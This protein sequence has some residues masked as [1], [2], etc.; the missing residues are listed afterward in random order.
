MAST[1][2]HLRQWAP[3]LDAFWY[4]ASLPLAIG[5][6]ALAARW[7]LEVPNVPGVLLLPLAYTAYRGGLAIGLA[8]ALLHMAHSAMFF[9][10]PGTLF[11]YGGGNLVRLMVIVTVAPAMA[12][13]IGM[14]RRKSDLAL[15]EL[16]AARKT[17]SGLPPSSKS[18]SRNG[19]PNS[20]GWPVTIR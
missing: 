7:G 6:V 19:L 3:R 4:L 20:P 9:S 16:E 14:L 10:L 13:M 11:Q 17:C 8:A 2:K 18:G 5:A 15:H 12:T 1:S